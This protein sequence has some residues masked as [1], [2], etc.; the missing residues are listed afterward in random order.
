[1]N[2][3][4]F[5]V[6]QRDRLL[7]LKVVDEGE[8]WNFT[9]SVTPAGYGQI[10]F[11]GIMYTA[12]RASYMMFKGDIP[13]ELIV[14]HTCDNR[15]C[16]NPDHLILGTNADNM[17]DVRDRGPGKV[18]TGSGEEHYNA[19]VTEEVVTGIRQMV[20]DEYPTRYVAEQFGV[21]VGD[22]WKYAT[23]IA[24]GHVPGALDEDYLS[25][26]SKAQ[27]VLDTGTKR[28]KYCHVKKEVSEFG[29]R[30]KALDGRAN[31]CKECTSPGAKFRRSD[32]DTIGR[33]VNVIN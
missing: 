10:M 11:D 6:K 28:C 25:P 14:R 22:V 30:S 20:K 18:V 29:Y 31:K 21:P 19:K 33:M 27:R 32:E 2:V 15:K 5:S 3:S 7:R 16:F 26:N 24:W 1:M 12:H 17:Q 8:C 9:N 4:L 13:K 23:G